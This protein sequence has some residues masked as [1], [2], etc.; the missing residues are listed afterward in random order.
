[1]LIVSLSVKRG[2]TLNRRGRVLGAATVGE[3]SHLR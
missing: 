1:V 3:L 2:K